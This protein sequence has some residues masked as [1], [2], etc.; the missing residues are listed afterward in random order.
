MKIWLYFP[1]TDLRK[2]IASRLVLIEGGQAF[3]VLPPLKS[4]SDNFT[5]RLRFGIC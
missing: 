1:S 2:S 4:N 3:R 5:A